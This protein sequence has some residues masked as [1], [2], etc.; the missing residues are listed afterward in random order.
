MK[1]FDSIYKKKYDDLKK[2]LEVKAKKRANEIYKER[3][4]SWKR[5]EKEWA[6]KENEYREHIRFLNL[7][8]RNDRIEL[9]KLNK[10]L[11]KV[12]NENDRFEL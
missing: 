10:Y 3:Q 4:E 11:D 5:K 9:E 6:E 2:N 12:L 7:T 1:L 8:I